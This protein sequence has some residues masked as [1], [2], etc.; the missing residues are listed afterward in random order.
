MGRF[1]TPGV[2]AMIAST[3]TTSQ[4]LI[5][6]T[7]LSS[8][9]KQY[10]YLAALHL[11]TSPAEEAE[12]SAEDLKKAHTLLESI[13]HGYVAMFFPE[14]GVTRDSLSPEW[15]RARDISMSYFLHYFNTVD[16]SYPDQIEKR[17]NGLFMPFDSYIYSE[18]GF[19]V[20]TVLECIKYCNDFL[21]TK[22]D[23]IHDLKTEAER[24]KDR[25][26]ALIPENEFTLER[27]RREATGSGSQTVF[28]NLIQRLN[29]LYQIPIKVLHEKFNADE[30][31]S[32]LAIFSSRRMP[33]DF[34]F[35]S[36]IS[37]YENAPLWIFKEDTV[38]IPFYK[39]L[40]S[41]AFN[42]LFQTLEMSSQK[43]QFYKNRDQY[44][45]RMTR[46]A[47]TTLERDSI[48]YFPSV[49]ETAGGQNEHDGLL[50]YG[51]DILIIE[52][53][54]TKRKE[55]FRDPDKAAIRIERD[56]KSDQGIQKAYDQALH[57]KQLILSHP[58]TSLFSKTGEVLLVL[59]R[60]AV[61]K[62][63]IVLITIEDFGAIALNL[64]VLLQKPDEESYPFCCS[65]DNIELI[66]EAFKYKGMPFKAFISYLSV[67]ERFHVKYM[68][69]DELEIA[70][71]Y[72]VYG[73]FGSEIEKIDKIGFTYGM[74]DIFNEIWYRKKGISYRTKYDNR[75]TLVDVSK[76]VRQNRA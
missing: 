67:R 68:S 43:Q 20:Q 55:P 71:Y 26:L 41:A 76:I 17:I 38:F 45:E 48:R 28:E 46:I 58:T 64:S 53:K 3:M 4:D 23:A 21:H 29:L 2:L 50:S 25:I 14:P 42:R 44:L 47:F 9:Y 13:V 31:D 65:I 22:L 10:M 32:F 34:L 33:R 30:I 19:H 39:T 62:I 11:S 40:F 16:L 6:S 63:Y 15:F 37:F 70:G 75:P 27:V 1:S 73:E 36:D 5:E 18:L 66:L 57:L 52:C 56:F 60:K 59:D 7:G 35:F 24:E 72:L 12:F 61:E 69:D 49:C 51:N 54:A 74:S 8:P